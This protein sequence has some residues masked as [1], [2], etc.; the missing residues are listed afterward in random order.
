MFKELAEDEFVRRAERG[1]RVAV[2]KE[3]LADRETPVAAFSR[4]SEREDAFLLES[5]AGGETRGRYSYLGIEPY[6]TLMESGGVVTLTPRGGSARTLPE[7]DALDALKRLF[8]ET[9]YAPAPELP[10]LQGGA[11]GY[12][13]YDAVKSFEPRVG[14]AFENGTPQK[15]FLLTDVMLV[16]DNVR[17][18]V[19]VVVVS[20]VAAHP[21]PREAYAAAKARIAAVH[22][23]LLSAR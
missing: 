18:T 22:E 6:A 3:F 8:A 11:V 19:T 21:S 15:A 9:H 13:A 7:R 5:V 20:D 2:F 16:F 23:R 1:G 17:D 4:L 12:V 10:S 14:L